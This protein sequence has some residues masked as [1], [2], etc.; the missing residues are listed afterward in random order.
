MTATIGDKQTYLGIDIKFER[1]D[2][3]AHLSMKGY[4]H[5]AIQK[6]GEIESLGKK[7]TLTPAKRDLFEIRDEAE[8]L[9]K[10]R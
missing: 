7:P 4:L 8:K 2:K 3:T 1:E 9:D 10:R 6:F 5:E